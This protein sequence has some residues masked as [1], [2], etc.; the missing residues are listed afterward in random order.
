MGFSYEKNG[1]DFC[2]YPIT[3]RNNKAIFNINGFSGYGII[4]IGSSD[5]VPPRPSTI[6]AQAKQYIAQIIKGAQIDMATKSSESLNEDQTRRIGN[7]LKGWFNAALKPK[8]TAAEGNPDLT[9]DA[10]HEY[11]AWSQIVQGLGFDRELADEN[12]QALNSL[13]NSVK[14]GVDKTI[15]KCVQEKDPSLISRLFKLFKLA[16]MLGLDGR[17]GLNVESIKERALKLAS[18][19]LRIATSIHLKY[20]QYSDDIFNANITGSGSVPLSINDNFML[21]GSGNFSLQKVDLNINVPN[22]IAITDTLSAL[23]YGFTEAINGD[24][25]EPFVESYNI[26]VTPIQLN[27]SP[28][29]KSVL[30]NFSAAYAGGEEP[31]WEEALKGCHPGVFSGGL[32][33]ITGWNLSGKGS[34]FATST[35]TGNTRIEG[36]DVKDTTTFELIFT[37]KK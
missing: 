36:L 26:D 34:V 10:A 3:V 12:E 14:R 11:L 25:S 6:Q 13:A 5:G 23:A 15:D 4:N 30:I 20:P 21:T 18:F 22:D 37:P 19:E 17:N 32:Y 33:K 1:K 24:R 35:L 16:T 7:I 31:V 29:P 9:E 8:L 2:F 28:D 27:M